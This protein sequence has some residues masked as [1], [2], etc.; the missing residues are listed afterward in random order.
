MSK[1]NGHDKDYGHKDDNVVRFERGQTRD[2]GW[3]VGPDAR[4]EPSVSQ[5]IINLPPV[6]RL[7]CCAVLLIGGGQQFLPDSVLEPVF[8]YGAFIPLRVYEA[9]I[10]AAPTLITHMFL[11]SGWLHVLMNLF[12]LAAF[13]AGIEKALG[14]RQL[15]IIFFASG[16]LGAAVHFLWAMQSPQPLIGASGGVSG[17]F[18][19]LCYWMTQKNML[20]GNTGGLGGLMPLVIIWIVTSVFFGYF[21]MPGAGGSIAWVVHVAGFLA[22]LGYYHLFVVRKPTAH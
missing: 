12:M 3:D 4:P 6:T 8:R 17:L 1:L 21:G 19:A 2:A 14:G 16:I 13:G 9:E 7:L 5:P 15:A 10:S 22:G 18:G 11:H 20:Q